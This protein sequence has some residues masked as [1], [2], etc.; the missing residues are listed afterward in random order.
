MHVQYVLPTKCVPCALLAA[1]PVLVTAPLTGWQGFLPVADGVSVL[2]YD[3]IHPGKWLREQHSPL[4]EA[5]VTSVLRQD[6]HHIGHLL[7][8]GKTEVRR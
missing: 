7:C 6:K 4:E 3:L 2:D 5:Q 1:V 8:R